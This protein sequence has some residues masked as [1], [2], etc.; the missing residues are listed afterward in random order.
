MDDILYTCG[1]NCTE[2]RMFVC[3]SLYSLPEF[4]SSHFCFRHQSEFYSQ[5][6]TS[7]NGFEG[8][9]FDQ[10]VHGADGDEWGGIFRKMEK[11][12][13]VSNT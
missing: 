11:L 1:S 4:N 2:C 5:R 12:E 3:D 10:Q 7:Q 6:P 8:S 13:H 9:H